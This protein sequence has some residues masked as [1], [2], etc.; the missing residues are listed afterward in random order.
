M[1]GSKAGNLFLFVQLSAWC[2]V[3]TYYQVCATYKLSASKPP[4]VGL[5]LHSTSE[6]FPFL[7]GSPTSYLSQSRYFH[8]VW[9]AEHYINYLFSRYPDS[10]APRPVLDADQFLLF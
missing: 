10:T 5:S 6:Y 8:T 1:A 7:V 3:S 4:L 2:F 9:E